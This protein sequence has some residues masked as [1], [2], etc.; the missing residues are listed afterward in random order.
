MSPPLPSLASDR[1]RRIQLSS[2][3]FRLMFP[4]GV[5]A[6]VLGVALWPMYALKV[7]PFYPG[8]AHARVMI[9][10]FFGAMIIGFLGTAGPRMLGVRHLSPGAL[11]GLF[12]LWASGVCAALV[13]ALALADALALVTFVTGFSLA[14]VRFRARDDLPPP[15]FAM[16]IVGLL[17]GATGTFCNLLVGLDTGWLPAPH[18]FTALGRLLFYQ[19]FI[20][21][22]ILGV[23]PFFFPRFGGLSNPQA[24]SPEA[25]VPNRTYLIRALI[26][27]GCGAALVATYVVEALG[28]PLAGSIIRFT[29]AASFVLWQIPLKYPRNVGT[30]GRIIQFA[31]LMLLAGLLLPGLFPTY[32]L[33]MLHLLFIGGFNLITLCVANWVIFAHSGII[34]RARGRLR[35]GLWMLGLVCLALATRISADFLLDNR[36]SHLTYAALAWIL[37]IGIW[38]WNVVPRVFK[39]DTD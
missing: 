13:N 28:G 17:S 5:A 10:G 16:V 26:A 4:A 19:A 2:E 23:A 29:I 36:L 25:R 24:T 15:G 20:L 12:A 27:A 31:V 30:L 9:G 22:P 35:Y 11:A 8:L 32:R 14:A 18:V 6:G 7:L 33:A 38:A 34:H 37:G 39:A 21:L 3:P 1:E